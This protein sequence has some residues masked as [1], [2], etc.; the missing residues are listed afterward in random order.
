MVVGGPNTRD[1]FHV[2]AGE[3]VFLQLEGSMVLRVMHRGEPHDIA[4]GPG[5]VF[6]LPGR[7]PHSPQ[8]AV[9][10]VGLV[11]ERERLPD[12]LDGLRWCVDGGAAAAVAAAARKHA[13][14]TAANSLLTREL[15]VQVHGR[16]Q[17]PHPVPGALPLRRPWQ[18]AQA[19]H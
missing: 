5:E 19:G 14:M 8:R 13:T 12:E 3:E 4:I 9:S 10:T 6:F 11:L 7:V 17:P 1:D 18:A 16:W 2:E 15:R